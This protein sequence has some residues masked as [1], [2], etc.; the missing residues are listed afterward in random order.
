MAR[1]AWATANVINL[2]PT[3]NISGGSL[4]LGALSP[5][6]TSFN[7]SGGTLSGTGTVTVSGASTLSTPGFSAATMT[8]TGTTRFD[9]ALSVTGAGLHD[10]TAGRR[11]LTTGTTTW[12]N[13]SGNAGQFRLG[14]GAV[15]ENRGLWLDDTSV[16]TS[17]NSSFGGSNSFFNTASGTYRKTGATTTTIKHVDDQ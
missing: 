5:T 6:V 11:L 1:I 15:V 9:G 13:S 2:G 17:V 10:F 4:D 7:H 8:G 3:L 16:S 14:G 12:T